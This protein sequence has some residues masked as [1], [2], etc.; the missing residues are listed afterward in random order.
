MKPTEIRHL[1]RSPNGDSWFLV[2]DPATRLPFVRHE[3]NLPSGGQVTDIEI[4]AFLSQPLHPEHE[5]LLR[6][7][8]AAIFGSSLTGPGASERRARLIRSKTASPSKAPR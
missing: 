7:I 4:S 6:L 2:C 5:A 3:A 1:Y 8:G